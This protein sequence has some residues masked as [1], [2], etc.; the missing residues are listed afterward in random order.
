MHNSVKIIIVFFVR[1]VKRK[2][3][4]PPIF[5]YKEALNK[6]RHASC[7]HIFRHIARK[8]L[9]IHQVFL[10]HFRAILGAASACEKSVCVICIPDL[11]STSIKKEQKPAN[12]RTL[13]IMTC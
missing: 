12:V 5:C 9:E 2:I 8:L 1:F 3:T 4:A 10:R 13:S 6:S 7:L 11:I